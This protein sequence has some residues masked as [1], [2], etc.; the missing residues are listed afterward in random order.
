MSS[1]FYPL[2]IGSFLHFP[3]LISKVCG[4]L[5]VQE[6]LMTV[7]HYWNYWHIPCCGQYLTFRYNQVMSIYNFPLSRH[8]FLVIFNSVVSYIKGKESYFWTEILARIVG[9]KALAMI[10]QALKVYLLSRS[11]LKW[12]FQLYST[13]LWTVCHNTHKQFMKAT[14]NYFLFGLQTFKDTRHFNSY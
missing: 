9:T 2:Q 13:G 4:R 1:H 11:Y 6:I 7:K 8:Y 3:M 5:M 12:K 10:V 14:L